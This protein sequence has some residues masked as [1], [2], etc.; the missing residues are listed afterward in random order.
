MKVELEGNE[1]TAVSVP[2]NVK[3]FCAVA[4]S[5]TLTLPSKMEI[6]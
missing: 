4:R 1:S 6:S 2:I 3:F 5:L